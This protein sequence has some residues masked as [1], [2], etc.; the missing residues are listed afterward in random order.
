MKKL[1]FTTLLA[2]TSMTVSLAQQKTEDATVHNQKIYFPGYLFNDSAALSNAMPALA[3]QVLTALTEK[4]KSDHEKSTN[5]YLLAKDYAHAIASIDSVQKKK[6][7]SVASMEIKVYA[8]AKIK[9][10][11]QGAS[12]EQEFK[13]GFSTAFG[14]L[15]F[16]K[17]VYVSLADTF[18]INQ[19]RDDYMDMV[20]KLKKNKTDSIGFEDARS[21]CDKYSSYTVYKKILPLMLPF[22]DVAPYHQL[23]PVFK[24]YKWGGVAPVQAIDDKADPS[25][26]YK[27]LMELTSFAAKDQEAATAKKEMNPGVGEVARKINL[28]V[29]AGVPQK[30]IDLVIVVHGNALN[31]LLSNEKYKRKYGIDNP[32]LPL[33]KELLDFGA[34]IVVCGQAMTFFNLEMQDLVPGIK[35]ALTAQ[36]VLSSYQLKGYVLYNI[37]LD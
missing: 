31:A 21:L 28:H 37:S 18:L 2:V 12:F 20:E 17:K 24:T 35:Q 15:S 14:R 25:L 1:L 5:L 19:L 34:R 11:A 10:G 3:Q 22:T 30:N 9:E 32:N 23:Y 4:E 6:D 27:L 8:G 29:A 7:D 26:R 33:L 36:T 16:S 13:Q